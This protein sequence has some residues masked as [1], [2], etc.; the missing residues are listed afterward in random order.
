MAAT[1]KP[2]RKKVEEALTKARKFTKS[3]GQKQTKKDV[4]KH[5]EILKRRKDYL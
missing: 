1:P 4:S 3:H 2:V 5:K